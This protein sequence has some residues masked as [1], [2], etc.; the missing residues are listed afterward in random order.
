MDYTNL[1]LTNETNV[2]VPEQNFTGGINSADD[3]ALAS[4]KSLSWDDGGSVTATAGVI[5]YKAGV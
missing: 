2:F 1:A 4:A 5:T 3:I